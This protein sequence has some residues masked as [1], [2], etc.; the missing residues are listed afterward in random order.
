M[1]DKDVTQFTELAAAPA[2]GDVFYIGDLSE[3]VLDDQNKK[4]TVDNL[5]HF[6]EGGNYTGS[7]VLASGETLTVASDTDAV[8]ILGKAKVGYDGATANV[9]CF[10]HFDQMG[11]ATFALSQ[12]SAGATILNAVT[13]QTI[14]FAVND[15][16]IFGI[17]ASGL[18]GNAGARITQFDNDD[19]M[20][21]DSATRGVTQAAVVG[22]VATPTITDFTSATHDHSNAAGGGATLSSP[23]IV[24]PTIASFANAAHDHA[25]A[26][27]GGSLG[28]IGNLT[29]TGVLSFSADTDTVHVLG[30]ARIGYDGASTNNA[31][32]AHYD[33]MNSTDYALNQSA[34]GNTVLNSPTGATIFFAINDGAIGNISASGLT[35]SAGVFSARAD[36]DTEHILGRMKV[37]YNGTDADSAAIAHYDYMTANNYALRQIGS[38]GI[39]VIN[40]PT[41][42]SVSFR[43]NDAGIAN[44]D[45]SGLAFNAGGPRIAQFVDEDDMSSDSAVMCP[46]QQSTKAYTD[47]RTRTITLEAFAPTAAVTTGDGKVAFVVPAEL[48]GKDITAVICGVYDKGITGTTDVV[49]RRRRAGVDADVLST[50]V[51]IGDEWF[52]ADGVIDTANDDLATGDT[53]TVD[54]DAIHSGTAPNG[55]TITIEVS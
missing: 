35:V 25:D 43:I 23:T 33:L 15:A 17:N 46:T 19:T 26:A 24:T 42:A 6:L 10:A 37:G 50:A 44:I 32:F 30:R 20:T 4:I 49:I 47:N 5:F 28:D 34:T 9:A 14:T 55:L 21:A 7:I 3:A 31:V 27:G 22:F 52:A 29:S 36:S 13:G 38:S 8:S 1:A 53:I 54:V 39:T 16:L 45:A 12:D 2:A 40:A 11:A 18:I 51:T 48:N 41:G